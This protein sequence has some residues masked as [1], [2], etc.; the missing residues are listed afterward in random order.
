MH[1]RLTH[2]HL[3][4]SL[5]F[6]NNA[7]V[8]RHVYFFLEPLPMMFAAPSSNIY[9]K[10]MGG[11]KKNGILSS[12]STEVRLTTACAVHKQAG[13]HTGIYSQLAL[14]TPRPAPP[15]PPLIFLFSL[16]HV[17]FV[18]EAWCQED[19]NNNVSE[20]TSALKSLWERLCFVFLRVRYFDKGQR[21]LYGLLSVNTHP[22]MQPRSARR[23]SIFK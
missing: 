5:L 16:C 14:N 21:K 2:N 12:P 20:N 22:Y 13:A 18:T 17:L 23:S 6:A 8:M 1:S 7:E 15:T 3:H 11:K 10:I 4:S 9:N 19:K